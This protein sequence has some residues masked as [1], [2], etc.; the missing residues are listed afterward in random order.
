M[1]GKNMKKKSIFLFIL[2]ITLGFSC[3]VPQKDKM[4]IEMKNKFTLQLEELMFFQ[5][6]GKFFEVEVDIDH[7][8][9]T[10]P[11]YVEIKQPDLLKNKDNEFSQAIS[12]VGCRQEILFSVDVSPDHRWV[13]LYGVDRREDMQNLRNPG[14]LHLVDLLTNESLQF[15]CK[16][17]RSY[18]SADS[19]Y[20]YFIKNW[21]L[22]QFALFSG[23]I[24]EKY[25]ATTFFQTTDRKKII[26]FFGH[27][28]KSAD[29]TTG[30][31]EELGSYKYIAYDSGALNDRYAYF[32]TAVSNKGG[33]K[34]LHIIDL[35]TFKIVGCPFS[36]NEGIVINVIDK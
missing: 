18:F 24:N 7:N 25:N 31:H 11:I 21:V 14:Q 9:F 17:N 1:R 6:T 22:S 36:L 12:I 35:D 8:R 2:F 16:L 10:K 34:Y 29:I 20:V 27:H 28:I 15:P 13:M 4:N 33:P 30:T 5:P 32:M 26:Y 3:Y 19:K 23:E